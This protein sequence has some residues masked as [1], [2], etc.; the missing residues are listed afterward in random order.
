LNSNTP[1]FFNWCSRF[2]FK[3]CVGESWLI[4]FMLFKCIGVNLFNSRSLEHG[5]WAANLD[6]C[7]CFSIKTTKSRIWTCTAIRLVR[8]V[9]NISRKPFRYVFG[10][11]S[12][13]YWTTNLVF[14]C[15]LQHQNNKIT[16]LDLSVNKI[17][18]EGTKYLSESLQVGFE[19]QKCWLLNH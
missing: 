1:L 10:S 17:G 8:R 13:G 7:A 3:W 19:L 14:L 18:P 11:K 5:Y 16:N 2:G 4:D 15:V 12:V 9:R 6:F